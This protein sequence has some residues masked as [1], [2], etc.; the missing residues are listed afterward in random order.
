MSEEN[1]GCPSMSEQ[2]MHNFNR[3]IYMY[4]GFEE[5]LLC[6]M[7]GVFTCK[8]LDALSDDAHNL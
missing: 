7:E 1:S 5:I 2:T 6:Q 4:F 8:A 3:F